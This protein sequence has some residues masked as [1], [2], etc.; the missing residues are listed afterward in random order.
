MMLQVPFPVSPLPYEENVP[1][2]RMISRNTRDPVTAPITI[3]V[4]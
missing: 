1:P 2:P 3:G 4:L